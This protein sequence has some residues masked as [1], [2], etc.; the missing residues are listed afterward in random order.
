MGD[1]TKYPHN[2]SHFIKT[3][4]QGYPTIDQNRTSFIPR[5]QDISIYQDRGTSVTQLGITGKYENHYL[6]LTFRNEHNY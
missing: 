5:G 6:H 3:S 4:A 2:Y 1:T